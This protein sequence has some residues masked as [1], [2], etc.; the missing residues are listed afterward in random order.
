MPGRQLPV[1]RPSPPAY[2]LREERLR[3]ELRFRDDELRFREE[4]FFFGTLAP[5]FRASES[6]MAIACFRL[7]TLPPCPLFPRFNVPC[8]R[9]RIALATLLLAPRP[10]F[11]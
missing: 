6:P 1:V 8:L 10:Y 3:D 5:F 9:R 11:R 2:D 4:L 7:F